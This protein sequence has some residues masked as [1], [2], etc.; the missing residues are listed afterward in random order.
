MEITLQVR[1]EAE[2]ESVNRHEL[3]ISRIPICLRTP[4]VPRRVMGFA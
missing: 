4:C 2:T 3:F 1:M